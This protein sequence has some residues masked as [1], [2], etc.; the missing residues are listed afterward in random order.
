MKKR[1]FGLGLLIASFLANAQT[2]VTNTGTLYISSNSDIF[3]AAGDL[4]N[5][6][7]ALTNN[8]PLY[9]RGTLTNNQTPATVGTGTLHLNGS[10]AQSVAGTATFKT[11]NLTTDNAAGI[12]LNNNL[13][14]SGIHTFTTGDIA[15]SVTPNYLVY[16]SGSSYT[17]AT[18]A[19]HVTGWVK[20]IGN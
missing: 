7:T 3:Y 8:G 15:S 1:F 12:T 5:T 9:V 18:D 4:T 16:E 20:K 11:Y 13:S 14:I 6:S 2:A 17:G 10:S 19:R